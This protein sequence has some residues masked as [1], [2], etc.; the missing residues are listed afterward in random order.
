MSL[1]AAL[2]LWLPWLPSFLIQTRRVDNE[3]WIQPPTLKTVLEHWRNLGSAFAPGGS[4]A[5]WSRYR[6]GCR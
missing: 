1:G 2:L 3:F 5:R 6:W 4:A